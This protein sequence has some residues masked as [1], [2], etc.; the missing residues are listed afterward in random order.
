[1][2]FEII[3]TS[4]IVYFNRWPLPLSHTVHTNLLF[5]NS[6]CFRSFLT[7]IFLP[8]YFS[9]YLTQ[10]LTRRTSFLRSNVHQSF[11]SLLLQFLQQFYFYSSFNSYLNAGFFVNKT[12]FLR[13]NV[14]LTNLAR[15]TPFLR[16]NVRQTFYI[17]KSCDHRSKWSNIL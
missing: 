14:S 6:L 15:R 8:D 13:S 10:V 9:S 7:Q 17:F 11:Y 2:K 12:H 16:S 5:F 4:F 1:M 3:Y